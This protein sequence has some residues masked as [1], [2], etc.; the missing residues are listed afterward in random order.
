MSYLGFRIGSFAEFERACE[1]ARSELPR[2]VR[3]FD[4]LVELSGV[5]P[6]QGGQ[7]I[8]AG[9]LI[10]E[11]LL[12]G[13][14]CTL[15]GYM[16]RGKFH[17]LAIVDSV[18]L[19][20]RVSFSRFDYPTRTA[21]GERR[22]MARIAERVMSRFGFDDGMFNI[23]FFLDH[24]RSSPMIIEINPRFSP[25][26]SDLYHKVDGVLGHQ[27][28]IELACGFEPSVR[29]RA[30][31]Y[32]LAASCVLRV[33]S[34]RIV[35]KAPSRREIAR[36]QAALPGTHVYLTAKTGDRLSNLVQDSFTFRYGLIHLGAA[37][38]RDLRKR[39][40][41]AK[42]MLTYDLKPIR[43]LYTGLWPDDERPSI[44]RAGSG[45]TKAG[46]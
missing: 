33:A 16:R 34:D 14:Q 23:E 32:K 13:R 17:F 30:G 25:Q 31:P 7:G 29:R 19:P 10:A 6:P 27:Y 8:N 5:T 45:K 26:Y 46:G 20:N 28:V 4:E 3:A 22:E 21:A 2:Y 18:R 1:L 42:R 36:L 15:E 40:S 24:R 38:R 41:R 43:G 44:S 12:G 35:R 37:D 11:E 39:L 9:W